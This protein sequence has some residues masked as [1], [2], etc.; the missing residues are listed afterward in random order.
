MATDSRGDNHSGGDDASVGSLQNVAQKRPRER[1]EDDGKPAAQRTRFEEDCD[2]P[3][4]TGTQYEPDSSHVEGNKDTHS[5]SVAGERVENDDSSS[6][7][8]AVN[9]SRR[10]PCGECETCTEPFKCGKCTKCNSNSRCVF[11]PCCNYGFQP[12]TLQWYKQQA[13]SV[14]MA[15]VESETQFEKLYG[16][17][18]VFTAKLRNNRKPPAAHSTIT[19]TGSRNDQNTGVLCGTCSSCTAKIRC[20][21]CANCLEGQRRCVFAICLK[22]DYSVSTLIGYRQKAQSATMSDKSLEQQFEHLYGPGGVFAIKLHQK[23]EPKVQRVTK[24]SSSSRTSR[25]GSCM[26]CTTTLTCKKCQ[27]CRR[28]QT[29]TCIFYPCFNYN[30][31]EPTLQNW[32]EESASI[33]VG[34]TD[35]EDQFERMY[36]ARGL[37]AAKNDT[38]INVSGRS[39]SRERAKS[40]SQSGLE[41]RCRCSPCNLPFSCQACSRCKARKRCVFNLC[42]TFAYKDS[43]MAIYRSLARQALETSKDKKLKK[44]FDKLFSKDAAT[45][46][47]Q[48]QTNSSQPSNGTRVYARWPEND[49]RLMCL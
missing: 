9:R 47:A 8:S 6:K 12:S 20:E 38:P 14:K 1:Q 29:N 42:Q 36:G 26:S 33:K 7:P 39:A 10:S 5:S 13:N 35:L 4:S 2:G 48:I 34:D 21:K 23:T 16:E 43:T 15:N 27:G 37:F 40:S 28:G 49:V 41:N 11:S 18:G 25:C 46:K 24:R 3:S 22:Y 17:N 19:T 32:R 30:Y 44:R 45:A 31:K